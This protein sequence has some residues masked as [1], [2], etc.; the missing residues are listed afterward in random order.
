MTRAGDI[1]YI[2]D[3]NG[4][5]ASSNFVAG[6]AAH[7]AF[8]WASFNKPTRMENS[9]T[10]A[11]SEFIYGPSRARVK[12][13]VLDGAAVTRTTTYIGGDF[14]RVAPAGAPDE[15]VHY[16]RAGGDRV[17]IFMKVDVYA[18]PR[19]GLGHGQSGRSGLYWFAVRA[20]R[21][22]R[23]RSAGYGTRPSRRNNR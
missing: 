19:I 21:L 13:T 10:G 2:Y 11:A 4:N 15:L 3:L 9:V 5:M 17:A 1:D 18:A 22:A 7:R 6:G 8:A 16:I 14:E 12:Q 20:R 23:R